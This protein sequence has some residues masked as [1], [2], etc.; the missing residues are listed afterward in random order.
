[1]N[2]RSKEREGSL[3][4]KEE[5]KED[6]TLSMTYKINRM[7]FEPARHNI[8]RNT[9]LYRKVVGY[10]TRTVSELIYEDELLKIYL[11]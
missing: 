7:N 1:M 9:S 2:A 10:K 11:W 3:I 6:D 8:D 4:A 5:C